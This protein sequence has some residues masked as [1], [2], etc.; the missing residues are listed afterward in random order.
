MLLLLLI[1]LSVSPKFIIL[2]LLSSLSPKFIIS[3]LLSSFFR[4]KEEV[5]NISST[6]SDKRPKSNIDLAVCVKIRLL[7]LSSSASLV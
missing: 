3:V 7:L 1:T 4:C 5:F 2:V 6:T